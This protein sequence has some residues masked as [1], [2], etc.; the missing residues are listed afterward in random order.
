MGEASQPRW[1][2]WALGALGLCLLTGALNEAV[3]ALPL[4]ARITHLVADFGAGLVCAAAALRHRGPARL[5]WLL[6]AGGIVAWAAGDVY[7]TLVLLGRDAVP[8]PSP[9]DVGYLLFPLLAFTGLARV[10]TAQVAGAPRRLWVDGAL[11]ALATAA[12]A[13]VAI[14]PSIVGGVGGDWPSAATN[15][16]YPLSDMILLGLVVIAIAVRGWRLDAI[17][18]LTAVGLVVFWAADSHYLVEIAQGDGGWADLFNGGWDIAFLTLAAAAWAP[19]RAAEAAAATGGRRGTILPLAFGAMA[20]G[21]LVY[22][23]LERTTWVAVVLAG[24]ALVAVGVRLFI[25]FHDNETM[26]AATRR[27]ALTDALTGLGNRRALLHDLARRTAKADDEDPAVLALFDLDGF[28]HYNDCY[29]HPAG[30]DLLV[31]LGA[32]LARHVDGQGKAYR[33]GGDEFCALLRPR[34]ADPETVVAGAAAA[35]SERGEGF[36][37]GASYGFVVAPVETDDPA[38]ALRLADQRMYAQK[39]G[40]RPSAGSQSHDV[41]M[42]ALAERDPEL[43]THLASV[44]DL[45]VA[46]AR[47]LGLSAAEVEQVRHAADL[48]D[49]GKVAIPDAILDKP[50][51]LDADEW[52]F[53]RRHTIIGERIVAAA[54]ALSAV[55]PLVRASH[56]RWDGRGYPDALAGERIPLGARIVAVCDSFDAMI[57]Q[58]RAYR[59]PMAEDDALAEL[60]RCAGTQFD[61]RVVAAF[62]EA[63]AE[64]RAAAAA[65]PRAA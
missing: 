53:M 15:A 59:E 57:D 32:N 45:A 12:V 28:K 55:A 50:G 4:S 36:A 47:K 42:R 51:P 37:I 54:P 34:G 13:A 62:R 2:W 29:G 65:V 61:P 41:L 63:L 38:E 33:M 58:D 46:V 48:H 21:V 49:V 44:A 23:G 24:V 40:G 39:H 19:A 17:W 43:R 52:A 64:A 9:A 30:D 22:A 60:Q 6:V 10:M 18:G 11:A 8:V 56:E 16:A 3:G 1:P 14:V 20:L 25:A 5:G 27:E 35:L 7:W 31:R 26:L